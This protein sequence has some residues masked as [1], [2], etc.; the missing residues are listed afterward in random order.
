MNELFWLFIVSGKEMSCFPLFEDSQGTVKLSL[1]RIS[2]LN[3]KHVDVLSHL[4]KDT[5]VTHV[6]LSE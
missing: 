6:L 4:L 3:S 1:K 5:S 2:N